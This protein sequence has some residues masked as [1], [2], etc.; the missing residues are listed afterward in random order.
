MAK[1]ATA[2]EINEALGFD[3]TMVVAKKDEEKKEEPKKEEEK[4][5]VEEEEEKKEE[6][7]K[8]EE[9][10]E[11]E[12]KEIPE[13]E[14]KEEEIPDPD[15]KEEEKKEEE[16]KEP[17]TPNVNEFL[18]KELADFEIENIEDVKDILKGVDELVEALEEEKK[19]SKEPSFKSEA[20]KKAYEFITSVGYDPSRY[21]EGLISHAKLVAMDIDKSDARSAMEEKFIIENP[22]LTRDEAIS[23]FKKD[24]TKKFEVDKTKFDDPQALKEEEESIRIDLKSEEAK[25]KKFLKQKQEEFKVPETKEEDKKEKETP[26]AIQTGIEKTVGEF[27]SYLDGFNEIT[28]TDDKNEDN[29]FTFKVPSQYLKQIQAAGEKYLSRPEIY[30]EKGMVPNHDPEDYVINLT[31]AL[32]GKDIVQAAL[33][34]TDRKAAI[35]T[36][37]KIAQV[38]PDKKG[39]VAD[40]KTDSLSFEKQAEMDAEKRVKERKRLQGR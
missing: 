40:G 5:E 8:E 4:K 11:E 27:K 29:K 35:L 10:K 16:K 26:A 20:Q 1:V 30:N 39:G 9:E 31:M 36:A 13:E 32:A 17:E 21:G 22:E 28:F 15:K 6:E 34:H 25:A 2:E 19:K 12:K 33:K 38:K 14:K 23:K 3:A 7:K 18:K 37:E 24:F